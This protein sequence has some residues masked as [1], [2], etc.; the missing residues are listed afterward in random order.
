MR[1]ALLVLP[2]VRR[3]LPFSAPFGAQFESLLESVSQIT[4]PPLL[5]STYFYSSL[6]S[7]LF[8]GLFRVYFSS[9]PS[10]L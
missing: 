3:T 5:K 2:F 9:L 10:S 8:F 4:V 6:Q 7:E 1:T